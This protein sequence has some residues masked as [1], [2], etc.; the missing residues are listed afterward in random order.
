MMVLSFL[1]ACNPLSKET[2]LPLEKTI[3]IQPFA[4]L[5]KASLIHAE[6]EIKKFHSS[7]IVAPPIDLPKEALN[8]AKTRHRAD[9]LIHSMGAQTPPGYVTM[10]LTSKDISTTKGKIADWGVMGLGLCPGNACVVS[11]FRLRGKNRMEK[12]AKITVHELGHTYG[13]PHCPAEKC[14]MRDQKGKDRLNESDRF[15]PK[16]KSHLA[17]AGWKMEKVFYF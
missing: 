10:G 14:L 15:C 2:T 17:Q 6:K 12:L 13:L 16:C 1:L 3:I 5:P 7:V 4:D 11:T 8:P 9:L